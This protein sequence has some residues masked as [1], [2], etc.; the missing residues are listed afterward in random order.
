MTSKDRMLRAIA[1]EAPDRLPTTIHQWQPYHLD[2]YMDGATD[3]EA[4]R[5]VGLDASIAYV[6]AV[7]QS[8][9]GPRL[10]EP[11]RVGPALASH[12]PLGMLA[13][14]RVVQGQVV[15]HE[16]DDETQTFMAEPSVELCQ[17]AW[18]T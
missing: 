4:F 1:R 6:A 15:R 13:S 5:R 10:V 17:L 3:L 8:Q 18:P 16:I 11:L 2:K 9:S 7:G 14:P 12:E